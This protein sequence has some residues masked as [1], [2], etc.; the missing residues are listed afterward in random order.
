MIKLGLASR[1]QNVELR[2]R[3]HVFNYVISAG[4]NN[5][6]AAAHLTLLASERR[7]YAGSNSAR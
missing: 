1:G 3:L 6:D 4:P 2:M 7:L 5:A